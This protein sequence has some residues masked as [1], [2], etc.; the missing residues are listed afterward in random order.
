MACNMVFYFDGS[1]RLENERKDDGM[2]LMAAFAH[3]QA[4]G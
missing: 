4:G 2:R 1:K 3:I